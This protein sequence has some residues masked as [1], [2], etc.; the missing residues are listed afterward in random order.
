MLSA[1]HTLFTPRTFV[2][3]LQERVVVLDGD[4]G[5]YAHGHGRRA[6]RH[7]TEG[8]LVGQTPSTDLRLL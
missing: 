2:C 7:D 5:R 3:P 4:G 8:R 6:L 1:A